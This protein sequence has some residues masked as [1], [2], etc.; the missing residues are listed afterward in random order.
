MNVAVAPSALTVPATPVPSAS[1]CSVTAPA[2]LAGA[3]AFSAAALMIAI[4]RQ[5]RPAAAS[6]APAK[7]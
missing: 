7:T 1:S 5:A 4:R 3:L 2:M 6:E